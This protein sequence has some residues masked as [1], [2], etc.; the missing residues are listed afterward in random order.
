GGGGGEGGL[1]AFILSLPLQFGVRF[2]WM[3]GVARAMADK[4]AEMILRLLLHLLPPSSSVVD[5]PLLMMTALIVM[6]ETSSPPSDDDLFALVDWSMQRLQQVTVAAVEK[7]DT[8]EDA[9]LLSSSSSISALSLLTVIGVA[10]ARM[11]TR[12]ARGRTLVDALYHLLEWSACPVVVVAEA[13]SRGIAEIAKFSSLSVSDLLVRNGTNVSNR[14]A[15]SSRRYFSNRR[16]PLVL[17][18]LLNRLESDDLFTHLSLIVEDLIGALDRHNIDW[19]LLILRVIYAYA[20]TIN[21][22]YPEQMPPLD[23]RKEFVVEE[24]VE[25]GEEE[26][27]GDGE[28]EEKLVEETPKP[29]PQKSVKMAEWILKRTKH[30]HSSLHLPVCILSLSIAGECIHHVRHWDDVLLPMVHQNWASLVPRFDDSNYECR[31]A[32]L[33]LL[34]RM[35]EVSGDFIHRKIRD[36]LW[37]GIESWLRA[38]ASAEGG[39]EL[40]RKLKYTVALLE[41]LPVIF[42]RCALSVHLNASLAEI[43]TQMSIN[44]TQSNTV[45]E[46]ARR[47]LVVLRTNEN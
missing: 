44:K 3:E 37:P 27:E 40:S 47:A 18:S 23:P 29:I 31:I 33:R 14:V 25:E 9:I 36:E 10:T 30:L 5:P 38:E 1:R 32:A 7:E 20:K 42:D 24:I 26:G 34:G 19:C 28:Q 39:F 17:S 41:R 16:C 35:A 8:V 11:K 46:A 43:C 2:E 6:Q 12:R 21:R 4:A 15:L 13:A 45:I 22:W